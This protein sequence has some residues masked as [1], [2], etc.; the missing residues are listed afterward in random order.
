MGVTNLMRL[1][2]NLERENPVEE[3]AAHLK[4]EY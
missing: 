1:Q 3:V 4:A 2:A